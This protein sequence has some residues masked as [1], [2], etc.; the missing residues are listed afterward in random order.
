VTATFA[1]PSIVGS[2]FSTLTLTAAPDAELTPAVTV[3][4]TGASGSLT[5]SAT[6]VLA[7]VAPPA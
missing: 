4:V 7:V 2:G 1:P 3:T 6:F 5:R